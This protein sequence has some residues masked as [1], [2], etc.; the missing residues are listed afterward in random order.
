MRNPS[1]QNQDS[2]FLALAFLLGKLTRQGFASREES[3]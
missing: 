2:D 1:K 3:A